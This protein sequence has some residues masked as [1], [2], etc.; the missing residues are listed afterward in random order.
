[1][2]RSGRKRRANWREEMDL[3]VRSSRA[4][5]DGDL[6]PVKSRG[7]RPTHRKKCKAKSAVTRSKRRTRFCSNCGF[8]F[9]SVDANFCANCGTKRTILE[10]SDSES[11]DSVDESTSDESEGGSVAST[12][13][14]A[15]S[16]SASACED[17]GEASSSGHQVQKAGRPKS[18]LHRLRCGW[19]VCQEN[20]TRTYVAPDGTRFKDRAK[21]SQYHNEKVPKLEPMRQDGWNVFVNKLRTHNLWIAPNGDQFNSYVSALAYSKSASVPFY[22]KDGRTKD[23][24]SFFAK[25]RQKDGTTTHPIDLSNT[26]IRGSVQHNR[27]PT[28]QEENKEESQPQRRPRQCA[29][30]KRRKKRPKERQKK[31]KKNKGKF[32]I[33][34]QNA[35]GVAL[36]NMLRD[37][38]ILR[39]QRRQTVVAQMVEEYT[40]K[41]TKARQISDGMANKIVKQ[42]VKGLFTYGNL[43]DTTNIFQRFLGSPEVR[44]I[45]SIGLLRDNRE[46]RWKTVEAIV[47]N[48]QRYLTVILECKGS[49][50]T[51]GSRSTI[52]ERAYR[53]VLAACSGENLV[54]QRLRFEASQCLV[55][56]SD[57]L[58]RSFV[59]PNRNLSQGVIPRNVS[60]ACNDR[61][62]LE[63]A[64]DSGYV[65]CSRKTYR[66]KMSDKVTNLYSCCTHDLILIYY[67]CCKIGVGPN[68]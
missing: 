1:M 63:E 51:G 34:K 50:H 54:K 42:L 36:Q 17:N 32:V 41:Y 21:A 60:R 27:G 8:K 10:S 22:G 9:I 19:S 29:R 24:T 53:T 5:G 20:G 16:A 3:R 66:N 56:R 28:P 6:V 35:D 23:I 61:T 4:R 39:N 45:G 67:H 46:R 30:E 55:R 25:Q 52:D 59:L 48:I 2:R 49:T 43:L 7:G 26:S 47:E 44:E 33:P 65:A 31:R 14:G 62:K 37:C 13:K 15:A 40:K 18:Q 57:S 58:T 68:R 38:R 64:P 12:D 11:D